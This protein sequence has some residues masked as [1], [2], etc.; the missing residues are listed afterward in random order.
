MSQPERD[1]AARLLW[2]KM[3]NNG[4]TGCGAV[5]GEVSAVGE[6][7]WRSEA[8]SNCSAKGLAYHPKWCGRMERH[9]A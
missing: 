7:V 8:L 6:L 2:C 1:A 4:V 3:T 5:S 9:T